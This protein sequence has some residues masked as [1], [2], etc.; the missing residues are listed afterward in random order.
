[1]L[2]FLLKTLIKYNKAGFIL[3]S[4]LCIFLSFF[5]TKLNID[6]SPETLLLEDDKDLR[7]FRELSS[8]FKD[9]DFLILAYENKNESLFSK[10]N[11]ELMQKIHKDLEKLEES[12]KILSL[13]NAVL[14]QSS[15]TKSLDELIKNP[16]NIFDKDVNLSKAKV[17]ITNN[18]FYVNNLISKDLKSAA[19]IIYLKADERYKKLIRLRNEAKKEDKDKFRLEL[20]KHQESELKKQE[21]LIK[22]I[23]AIIEKYQTNDVMLHLGGVKMIVNDMISYIKKDMLNYSL[24]L[25]LLLAFAL[26]LFFRQLRF[27]LIAL[28]ICFISLFTVSGIFAL[29]NF[30][31]TVISSN[32]VPL[33]LIISLSLIIHL[34]THFIEYSNKFKKAS[35]SHI[36]LATLLSKAKPSFY[37]ILTTAIG[38][39]SLIFSNIK[40]VIDLGIMMSV[41]IFVALILSYVYFACIMSL[42]KKRKYV[43]TANLSF[44]RKLAKFS[45]KK[46]SI[47]YFLS[48]LI[49]TISLI[50]ISKLRV[51][52][53]FVSYFKDSS[54]IKQGMLEIDQKLGGTIPL[55][56]I[57]KFKDK[58]KQEE[59]LDS[60]EAEFNELSKKDTYFFDARKSRIAKEL[61]EFLQKQDFV[62]S[63][64]SF[65][66]LL[67]FGKILNDGK[68]LD[69]FSLAFLN[70]N[71][72]DKLKQDLLNPYVSMEFNE[73]RFA[74]RIMDSN[75]SLVRA[76]FLKNLEKNS[77]E[78]LKD[79][80]VEL[81][82]TNIMLLYN[83]MLQSLF[84]SQFDTLCFVVIAI[85]VLFI[86]VFKSVKLASIAIISNL[87]PLSLVFAIMGFLN[88]PLDLM[89]ITIA[90]ISIGIGVDDSIHYIHRFQK[91][92]QRHSTLKSILIAHSQIGA[93]LF[94][95]TVCVVLG[96][97]IMLS[98]EFMPTIYFGLLTVL[99]MIFLL[100]G[101]L[102]LLAS[103]LSSFVRKNK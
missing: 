45:V 93:A 100:S 63:V 55:D 10:A 66:S 49:I 42:L 59:N 23:R 89:S 54:E 60:F 62:A 82:I 19:F 27:I 29:S 64:M 78:L 20:K 36:V 57:I 6:A 28:F 96:F 88:I 84:S 52:N 4:L 48:L 9:N 39:L 102:I 41:A 98:S 103:L 80:D 40:P 37:A 51:E 47:I 22:D 70:E 79:E 46:S 58:E 26:W 16:Q 32:F 65:N 94:Y 38:F 69:D 44:L 1:M 43:N 8:H 24:A 92:K 61:H 11:L 77:K 5:A 17:E 87:I 56:I 99:V 97:G 75:E 81:Y 74:M 95:T 35:N 90:A 13:V 12:E 71:M 7:L 18:P 3:T 85:F 15:D 68:N 50:G 53:S 72:P 67:E 25:I 34:N 76:E 86:F 21:K 101:S 2:K 73:F 83:N 91:E 31:I 14:L 33:L 30:S